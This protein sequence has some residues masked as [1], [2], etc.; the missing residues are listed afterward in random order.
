VIEQLTR[1]P[2][3]ASE[4]AAKLQH[5]D[6]ALFMELVQWLQSQQRK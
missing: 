3:K 6:P 2:S 1:D 5:E 4:I